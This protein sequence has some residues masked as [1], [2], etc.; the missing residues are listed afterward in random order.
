MDLLPLAPRGVPGDDAAETAGGFGELCQV[1]RR[2]ARKK[3][4][5]ASASGARCPGGPPGKGSARAALGAQGATSG[6]G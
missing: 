1:P 6:E 3:L 4:R 5:R 2:A